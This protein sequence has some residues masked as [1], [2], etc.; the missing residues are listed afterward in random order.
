MGDGADEVDVLGGGKALDG[1]VGQ[2][3]QMQ[4]LDHQGME[5]VDRVVLDQVGVGTGC[6][7]QMPHRAE[8]VRRAGAADGHHHLLRAGGQRRHEGLGQPRRRQR[9]AGRL[10]VVLPRVHVEGDGLAGR[11]SCGGLDEGVGGR[12]QLRRRG[13]GGEHV[14]RLVAGS[15]HRRGHHV[16]PIDGEQAHV[17]GIMATV[18]AA[19]HRLEHD[20]MGGRRVDRQAAQQ[21]RCQ[22]LRAVDERP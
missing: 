4:P 1:E 6:E 16:A 8:A 12:R 20:R 5:A 7:R 21:Q 10:A 15:G 22:W 3:P 2:A 9:C 14:H 11:E 19:G 18:V 17:A 13:G